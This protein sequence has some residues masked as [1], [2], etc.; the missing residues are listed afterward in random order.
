MA[1]D[2][3]LGE[4]KL[5]MGTG[6]VPTTAQQVANAAATAEGSGLNKRTKRT[7]SLMRQASALPKVEHSLDEFI[8][9]ANQ[10]LVDVSNWGTADQQAK[11]EEEKRREL[12][13]LRWKQAETQMKES[14]ARE[15]SLRRQL[16]GLQ[17]KLAEAEARAAVA[18]TKGDAHAARNEAVFAELR[19]RM[20]RSRRC[21]PRSRPPRPG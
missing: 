3:K 5:G 20:Q 13:A 2:S 15:Q 18:S 1:V 14:D 8:A 9:R 7:S 12:D 17:G 21:V 6:N 11:E 16:D 19:T 10:T 4:T